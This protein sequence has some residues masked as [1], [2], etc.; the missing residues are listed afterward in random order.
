MY[1]TQSGKE[2]SLSKKIAKGGEG[3]VYEIVGDSN[4]CIKIY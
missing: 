1:K 2:I 3:E 4:N